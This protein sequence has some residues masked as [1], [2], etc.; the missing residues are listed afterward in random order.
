VVTSYVALLRG[1]NLG[2]RK[3]TSADLKKIGVDAGYDAV[4]THLASGNLVFTATA[5]SAADHEK[6]LT[7]SIGS[8]MKAKVPVTVRT[9]AQLEKAVEGLRKAYPSADPKRLAIGFLDSPAGSGPADR[10]GD[11]GDDQ[12]VISGAE[13]YLHYPNGQ[14]KS[15]LIPPLIDKKLGGMCTVRGL[16]TVEGIIGKL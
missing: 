14:A 5:G 10:L 12:Y 2:S 9:K 11:F 8:H 3:L 6:S 15:K 13:I 16:G 1:V 4:T 7:A